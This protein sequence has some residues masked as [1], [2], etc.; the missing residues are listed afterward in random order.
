MR[1]QVA[2]SFPSAFPLP[3]RCLVVLEVLGF[4]RA[5]SVLSCSE[6]HCCK[7]SEVR[8]SLCCDELASGL[9]TGCFAGALWVVSVNTF[10]AIIIILG[11]CAKKAA[12]QMSVWFLSLS[13]AMISCYNVSKLPICEEGK[14]SSPRGAHVGSLF[15]PSDATFSAELWLWLGSGSRLTEGSLFVWMLDLHCISSTCCGLFRVL[16]HSWVLVENK[17]WVKGSVSEHRL[18]EAIDG[19]CWLGVGSGNCSGKL[20]CPVFLSSRFETL[21]W[22]EA[23]WK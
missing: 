5:L 4:T 9:R 20:L 3:K 16:W 18:Q 10:H 23:P 2:H 1:G 8:K 11:S 13:C 6:W 17:V 19:W 7:V 15:F 14:Q 12:V 21:A 22:L